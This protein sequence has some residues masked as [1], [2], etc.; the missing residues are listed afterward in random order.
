M[1][2]AGDAAR[3]DT[4]GTNGVAA[5]TTRDT[6]PPDANNATIAANRKA[7]LITFPLPPGCPPGPLPPHTVHQSELPGPPK[8]DVKP[9]RHV[10]RFGHPD[11]LTLTAARGPRGRSPSVGT[12]PIE[13]KRLIPN[14][15]SDLVARRLSLLIA[16]TTIWDIRSNS[17]GS[18]C[19]RVERRRRSGQLC[20]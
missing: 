18:A 20:R 1:A 3:S 11:D 5:P 8:V 6:I 9:R 13:R 12:S 16:S 14:V 15:S 19:S 7:R 17:G 10:G 2:A 4:A